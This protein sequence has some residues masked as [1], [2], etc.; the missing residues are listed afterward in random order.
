M[1]AVAT[2][3]T[4]VTPVTR[5]YTAF[6]LSGGGSLGALQVGM[7]RALYEHG[8]APDL[9]VGTSAGAL[10]AAFI[11]SRPQTVATSRAL[12]RVWSDLRR[13]DLFPVSPWMLLGGLLG[14]RD[15]LV[16]AR[17]LRELVQRHLEFEDLADAPIPL[18]VIAF[19]VEHGREVRL[20]EGSALDAVNGAAAVPGVLAPVRFGDRRLIDGGVVN[21]TPISHAVELGAERIYVLP[22]LDPTPA[23][24]RRPG[25]PLSAAIDGLGLLLARRFEAD[26]AHFADQAELIVLPA[27]NPLAIQ[28][29]D[30]GHAGRLM[31]DALTA[32]RLRLAQ[33]LPTATLEGR[34]RAAG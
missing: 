28:P 34:L 19:D 22:T 4:P 7:L 15:H 21:N 31:R 32:A 24:G 16:P 18:H 29:T 27:P 3:V 23:I 13:D 8:A 5:P 6:V 20:S 14:R 2:A 30:F 17:A 11:A 9:L 26:I 1:S 12:G 10:N 33:P 25:S